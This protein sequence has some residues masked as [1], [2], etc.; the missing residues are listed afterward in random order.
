MAMLRLSG[1]MVTLALGA[2]ACGVGVEGDASS[3]LETQSAAVLSSTDPLVGVWCN[4]SWNGCINIG[5]SGDGVLISGGDACWLVSDILFENLA[6]T[7]VPNQYRGNRNNYGTGSC[8]LPD[9]RLVTVTTA[10]DVTGMSFI[11]ISDDTGWSS[12]WHKQ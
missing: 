1:I 5:T 7:S 4:A 8:G 3:T 2:S 11:E 6:P 12:A 10:T 9:D